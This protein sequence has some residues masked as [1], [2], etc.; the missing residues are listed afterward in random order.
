MSASL[1]FNYPKHPPKTSNQEFGKMAF[2]TF[3]PSVCDKRFCSIS[4]KLSKRIIQNI[5]QKRPTKNSE[6]RLS[7]ILDHLLYF[8]CRF[9]NPHHNGHNADCATHGVQSIKVRSPKWG[10]RTL[11]KWWCN[12]F[13]KVFWDFEK[14]TFINVLF[15]IFSYRF[16]KN[17][18]NLTQTIMLSF[19]FLSWKFC[20]DNFLDIFRIFMKRV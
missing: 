12:V 19:A 14:R 18:E 7:K 11:K 10:G 2:T 17:V 1:N 15:L 9:T 3:G 5:P 6:K 20:Y 8:F 13:S 4:P 16:E